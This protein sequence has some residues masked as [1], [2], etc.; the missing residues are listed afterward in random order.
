MLRLSLRDS[1][2]LLLVTWGLR[3]HLRSGAFRVFRG[4][5]ASGLTRGLQPVLP[6][7]FRTDDITL[8]N[9]QPN[10]KL[11]SGQQTSQPTM[12]LELC[13]SGAT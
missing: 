2:I 12:S 9:P 1:I 5:L 13:I 10:A 3:Q 7:T 4:G 8:P 11:G 6:V